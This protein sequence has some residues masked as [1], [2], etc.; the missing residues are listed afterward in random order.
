MYAIY[1]P[2]VAPIRL[3]LRPIK[4]HNWLIYLQPTDPSDPQEE[5]A[6]ANAEIKR[7]WELLEARDTPASSDD[8]SDRLTTILKALA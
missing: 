3:L 2:I 6:T 8:S 1:Q 4:D 5:L 7:L